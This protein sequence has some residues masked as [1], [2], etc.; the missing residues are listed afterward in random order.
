M[1][2]P[3]AS[4]SLAISTVVATFPDVCGLVGLPPGAQYIMLPV[5]P[6]DTLDTDLAGGTHPNGD[7]TAPDDGW[8]TF[9]GTSGSSSTACRAYVLL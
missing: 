5:E 9:S 1:K 2:Q 6:D 4:G 8:A 3:Y 7:E